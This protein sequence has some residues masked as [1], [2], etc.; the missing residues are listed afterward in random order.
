LDMIQKQLQVARRKRVRT[1]MGGTLL[2]HVP[3]LSAYPSCIYPVC[4]HTPAA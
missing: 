2:M 4:R 3:R 1:C